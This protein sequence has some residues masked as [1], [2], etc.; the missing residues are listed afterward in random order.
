M[1][2]PTEPQAFEVVFEEEQGVS[3]VSAS[4]ELDLASSEELRGSLDRAV[5]R[6]SNTSGGVVADFSQVE[7]VD[8]VTLNILLEECEAL[9]NV[10][11]QLVLVTGDSGED[12]SA[13]H[14]VNRI[15]D[16]TGQARRFRSYSSRTAAV[17]DIAGTG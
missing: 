12:A 8:V 17:Q 14:P 4:G 9:W 16:L 1:K 11:K 2:Y 7:F 5:T 13:H 6:C 15:L 3:V 10:G